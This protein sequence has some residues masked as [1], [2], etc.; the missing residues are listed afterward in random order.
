MNYKWIAFFMQLQIALLALTFQTAYCREYKATIT[1]AVD[2]TEAPRKILHAKESMS[3][4]PGKL[5]LLYPQWIP[6]EHGPTGPVIDLA[7]LHLTANGKTVSWRRDLE[8]M[9]AIHCEIPQGGRDLTLVFDFLL[10]PEAAGFS[11]GA[12][13]S[14]QLV[15]LSWN[16]VILYPKNV[17]PDAIIVTP[18]V[19]LPNGWKFGS[20]LQVEQ[21]S[22]GSIRFKP[23]SLTMLID[24]PVLAG[25]H[26]RRVDISAGSSTPHFLDL[27]SDGD[28]ALNINTEQVNAYE[29]LVKEAT[30]LFGAHHYDHYD[31]L[32]TLSDQVAH[33]GLEH[34]QSSDDRVA[35]RTLIDDDL[36]KLAAT[37]LPHEFVHSWNGKYRRPAGLATGDFSTPMKGELLW[38]YEGLTQ[39]LGKLLAARSGL[40][41]AEEYREDLA[42]LAARLDN[43]PGRS[44]RPLQDAA[45][46][47]QLLYYGRSDWE[48]FRRGTDFYDEGDL[49]WLETDM[50]IR[51]MTNG[52]KS[53]NDFC[54]NFHGGGQ[55]SGP[56]IKTYTFEDVVTGLK[57]IVPYDWDSFLKERLNSLN[58]H[59][60]L[61]GIEKGGWKLT[62]KDTPNSMQTAAEKRNK[63]TDLWYSLGVSISEDGTMN[64]VVPGTPAASAGI[65]P[66]M[67]LIAVNGRKFSKEIIRAAIREATHTT[68][69]MELLAANGEF[70]K[71][72]SVDYHRGDR[73]PFLEREESK[74]DLLSTLIKP[75]SSGR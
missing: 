1:L 74:P 51:Q 10:P 18:G 47:A 36:R 43:R 45:D 66:G 21:E 30:S 27:A 20:A 26:F 52:E 49:L 57:E 8:D 42:L 3:V 13:S 24:S 25:A 58:P 32:F 4:Q 50:M 23:V 2:A 17:T 22:N 35:E 68:N 63:T 11:S 5:T 37:L 62:Y 33:F 73:Y 69:P 39:Y 38:V 72:Y 15:V 34:H 61:G 65:A 14:A 44:W 64:D 54:R 40:R 12:S 41:T 56:K 31:F 7:G 28:D 16:Q 6:G 60:P 67:K 53:L 19:M 55:D 75:I 9:Y 59:A 46:E 48:S 70:F 29:N 71:T